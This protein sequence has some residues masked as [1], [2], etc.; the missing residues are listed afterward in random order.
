V[1]RTGAIFRCRPDGSRMHTFAIGFN[2]PYGYIAFDV[3]GNMFHIDNGTGD[4]TKFGGCRLLH[5]PEG[6]DFGW[7]LK[8]G[9]H[10][11]VPDAMRAAVSGEK[12]GRMAPMR[13]TGRGAASGLF[14][15]ND[16]R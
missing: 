11:C 14:I 16:T 9:A 12:P 5:V 10:C 1:L 15:Y 7:R 13:K 3:A 8:A 2:N 6:A 4:D